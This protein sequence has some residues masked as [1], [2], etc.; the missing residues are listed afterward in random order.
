MTRNLYLGADLTPAIVAPS[1]EALSIAATGR[2][3]AEVER[4]DFPTR[5]EG[6]AEEILDRG[7]RPGRPAGG[8]PLA[9]GAR[10]TSVF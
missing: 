10:S 2:S 1:L 6:L 7:T 9:H 3:C 8:R 5:A 4:N